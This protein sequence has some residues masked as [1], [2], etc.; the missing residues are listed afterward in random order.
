MP[1]LR[2]YRLTAEAGWDY[3][4]HPPTRATTP[5]EHKTSNGGVDFHNKH[6]RPHPKEAS[7]TNGRILLRPHQHQADAPVDWFVT[8]VRSV[9]RTRFETASRFYG[10]GR[11]Q[12]LRTS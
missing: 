10:K 3:R 6:P 5:Q 7:L 4:V 12:S 2:P 9:C 1:E 8:A 11:A